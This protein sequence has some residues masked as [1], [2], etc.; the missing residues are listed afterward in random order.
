[1]S[2]CLD[3][4]FCFC[5][6]VLAVVLRLQHLMENRER[7]LD[8]IFQ[9]A[10]SLQGEILS[11]TTLDGHRCA[12]P[13]ANTSANLVT[14]IDNPCR[15]RHATQAVMML[16]QNVLLSGKYLENSFRLQH[17]VQ[18]HD[19]EGFGGNFTRRICQTLTTILVKAFLPLP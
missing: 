9:S 19:V 3:L 11:N 15:L 8:C 5:K 10:M 7:S 4:P 18:T 17:P 16:R 1:M 2:N 12:E 6:I 14:S 13:L